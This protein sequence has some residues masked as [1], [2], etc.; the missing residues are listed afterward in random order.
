[1]K[2]FVHF[3]VA[4]HFLQPSKTRYGATSDGQAMADTGSEARQAPH[5][6]YVM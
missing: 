4:C 6:W 5:D 2:W 3:L 1:M